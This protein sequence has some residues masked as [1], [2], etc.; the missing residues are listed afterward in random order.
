MFK[1][2]KE[3][4]SLLTHGQ[5]KRFWLLQILVIL[6]AILEVVGIASIGP[7]MA[8]V[9]DGSLIEKN[10]LLKQLYQYSGSGTEQEFLFF[11]GSVVLS[12]LVLSAIVSMFT[13]WRISIFAAEFGTELADR[14]Y[15]HYM[16]QDWLFHAKGSSSQL[17][18]GISTE[19]M[20]VTDLIINPLMQMNARI[21]TMVLI[22]LFIILYD[23]I[24]AF[25]GL[26]VFTLAYSLLYGTVRVQL[27]KNGAQISNALG[28]RFKLMNEGFGSIKDVL[29]LGRR[30]DFIGR[31]DEAGKNFSYA[32]GTNHAITLVP[33]YLME[34]V[35]FGSMIGLVLFLL[36]FESNSLTAVL[37][38][39]SV[40]ALAGFKL[41]PAFQQIYSSL[42]QVKG[43]V[44]SFE[45]I[46]KDLQNSHN[47][48][49]GNSNKIDND[50]RL[51]L[52]F[53]KNIELNDI[54]FSYKR[55]IPVL[56]KLNIKIPAKKIV[57]IVGP[58]GSGKSTA[59]DILLGLIHPQ[60][61]QLLIDGQP[62]TKQNKRA[63]QNSIGFV[64]QAIFLSEN[65]IAENI[66]FGIPKKEVDLRRVHK[67]LQLS[68]LSE[69]V[70]SL[71]EGVHTK[72]GERG[73][74]LSGGQRQRIGIARALYHDA[75][76]LVFDE[77]TSSLDGITEKLIMDAIHDF[78]GEKT[79]IMIAHRLKTIEEC[80]CI[81]YLEGGRVIDQGT[82]QQL[83]ERNEQFRKMA[84]H[85]Q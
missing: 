12:T 85:V 6:M 22:S 60:K 38:T 23:P 24:I 48:L 14:L 58:S 55:G 71:D 19:S 16:N 5:R 7:F 2:I 35:A 20:R 61:G 67:A 59:M 84:Q 40:Y 45:S 21:V 56:R 73:V 31:F 52:K 50:T 70:A 41:L 11:M 37:P 82:Y 27:Q 51:R 65:S 1:L 43:N 25:F 66:A 47:E 63:W 9:S 39:L 18:K 17:I 64:A 80:D 15:S 54:N 69:F 3:L 13:I 32:R 44:A 78:G 75:D 36:D 8:I 81:F 77:A 46:K 34:L 74:Q 10:P 72:V 26:V 29:L 42:A 53:N 83:I 57:G 4:F 30:D 76:T 49:C 79:I 28:D 68:H 62:I 33:R